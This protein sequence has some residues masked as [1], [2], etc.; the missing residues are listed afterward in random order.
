MY[1][2]KDIERIVRFFVLRHFPGKIW[3][4]TTRLTKC[5]QILTRNLSKKI[6]SEKS[7]FRNPFFND[8]AEQSLFETT[9]AKVCRGTARRYVYAIWISLF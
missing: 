6:F 5:F 2:E 8:V 7:I 4:G 1:I 9:P 3:A